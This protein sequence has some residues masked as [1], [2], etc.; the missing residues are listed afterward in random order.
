VERALKDAGVALSAEAAWS[1]LQTVRHVSFRVQGQLRSGVTPGSSRARQ[2]LK[3]L[4]LSDTRPPMPP[5]GE[6]TT[7]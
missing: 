2:V 1:A 7:M 4:K 6:E 5:K 3:A